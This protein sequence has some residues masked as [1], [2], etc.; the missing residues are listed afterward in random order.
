MAGRPGHRLPARR[1]AI[2]LLRDGPGC[3]GRT[4]GSPNL[5][6]PARLQSHPETVLTTIHTQQAP[7]AT[8]ATRQIPGP[9]EGSCCVQVRV[10]WWPSRQARATYTNVPR[11]GMVR[12][13]AVRRSKPNLGPCRQRTTGAATRGTALT[14]SAAGRSSAADSAERSSR[15]TT[16]SKTPTTCPSRSWRCQSGEASRRRVS[17]IVSLRAA[18]VASGPQK[19]QT[20]AAGVACGETLPPKRSTTRCL[21]RAP[22]I[23]QLAGAAAG[24]PLCAHAWG[25]RKASHQNDPAAVPED[26]SRA[27]ESGWEPPVGL[28]HDEDPIAGARVLH[29]FILSN[30][31]RRRRSGLL[32][33]LSSQSSHTATGA[34]VHAL[35]LLRQIVPPRSA[36]NAVHHARAPQCS[37]ARRTSVAESR[38][39]GQLSPMAGWLGIDAP[40]A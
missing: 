1:A 40:T 22:P 16:R 4:T 3:P 19:P 29:G 31:T 26:P 20:P 9:H 2:E 6:R 15:G 5:G 18:I 14:K 12:I 10:R 37:A 30:R 35:R 25:P 7:P 39:M 24:L 11:I 32:A 27:N 8:I 21:R 17:S 13:A 28:R 33:V 36:C 34:L 38:S 23:T